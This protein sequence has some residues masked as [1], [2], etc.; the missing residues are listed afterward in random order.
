MGI[1]IN[2]YPFLF[3][4]E[5]NNI[6]VNTFL[7]IFDECVYLY[8]TD[9]K[10]I[11]IENKNEEPIFGEY[12]KK[13]LSN[14]INI[15]MFMEELSEFGGQSDLYSKFGLKITDEATLYI[16]KRMIKENYG[17][18]PMVGDL[19]FL[20]KASKLFEIQH[21]ED[22]VPSGFYPL[23]KNF[24]LKF[25]LKMYK[26]DNQEIN[27]SLDDNIKKIENYI[28]QEVLKKNNEIELKKNEIVND[29]EKEFF[30]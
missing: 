21:I 24:V 22:E 19:I 11:K 10:Y 8:G 6:E 14:S 5:K 4:N 2:Q 30:N 23:G 20:E 7:D 29:D 27:S 1:N 15:R 17:I 25:S 28:E 16:S 12:L 9:V 13:I 18:V 26:Y 3:N